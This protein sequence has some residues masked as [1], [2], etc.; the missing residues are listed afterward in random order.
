M[1]IKL[2]SILHLASLL[3]WGWLEHLVEKSASYTKQW[4]CPQRMLFSIHANL[5]SKPTACTCVYFFCST[6]QLHILLTEGD[7]TCQNLEIIYHNSLKG[8]EK[9]VVSIFFRESTV[10]MYTTEGYPN[11][12][13]TLTMAGLELLEVFESEWA[14]GRELETWGLIKRALKHWSQLL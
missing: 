2:P 5:L 13:V 7:Y 1:P 8:T 6:Y 9:L 14:F 3:P 12:W 11:T 10:Y 4:S